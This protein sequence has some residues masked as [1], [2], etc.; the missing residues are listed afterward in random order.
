MIKLIA[1]LRLLWLFAEDFFIF[2]G[3]ALITWATFLI[4]NIVGL[5]VLG[6]FFM[7]FGILLSRK[8]RKTSE[9]R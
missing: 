8:A 4:N 3:A 6:T 1:S 5:Y 7:I 2:T 9:R